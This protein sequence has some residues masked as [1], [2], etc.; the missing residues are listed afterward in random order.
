[1]PITHFTQLDVWKRATALT[2][3]IYRLTEGFP[4]REWFGLAAQMRSAAFSI[5]ANLSEGFGRR[6]L[7]DKARFYNIAEGSSKELEN[8]LILA[9]R[10]GYLKEV[11]DLTRDL[12]DIGRM[13][14][15][16]VDRTLEAAE[17]AQRFEPRRPSSS[18]PP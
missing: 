4:R 7:R 3:R 12:E 17:T 10:L 16:L 5:G 2:E 11:A 6:P 8:Y 1:M 13:L 15:R 14:T 9:G 18:S